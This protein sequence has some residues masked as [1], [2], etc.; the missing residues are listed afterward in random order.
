M[1]TVF[2][3]FIYTLFELGFSL[4]MAIIFLGLE[5][6]IDVETTFLGIYSSIKASGF[7]FTKESSL[8]EL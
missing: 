4:S 1:F 5:D 7:N 8:N 6:P 2:A 3:I